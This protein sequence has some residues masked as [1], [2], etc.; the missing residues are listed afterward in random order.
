M[1]LEGERER[2]SAR[3]RERGG[4][5]R[6]KEGESK[7]RLECSIKKFTPHLMYGCFQASEFSASLMGCC[8]WPNAVCCKN[9]LTCCP[10]G[11]ECVD[12]VPPH[13]FVAVKYLLSSYIE[14]NIC[15]LA[16]QIT[17]T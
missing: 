7:T 15:S 5:E 10:Q 17:V 14:C 16:L 13:W 8:P 3:E 12:G 6:E 9:R 1:V 11:T 4:R 2:E